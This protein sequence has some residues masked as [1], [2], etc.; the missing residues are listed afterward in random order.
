MPRGL[1]SRSGLCQKKHTWGH[2]LPCGKKTKL[3]LGGH[4]GHMPS[5]NKTYLPTN[6]VT[7][8]W[9]GYNPNPI[10]RPVLF[11]SSSL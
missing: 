3:A 1:M 10:L 9:A 7:E 8:G 4:T 2:T 11:L 5:C 6:W